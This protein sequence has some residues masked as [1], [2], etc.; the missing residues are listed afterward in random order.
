MS[1]AILGWKVTAVALHP[2]PGSSADNH[3][4][5]RGGTTPQVDNSQLNNCLNPQ[6]TNKGQVSIESPSLLVIKA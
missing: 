5:P 6:T 1:L 4:M 2:G 3:L